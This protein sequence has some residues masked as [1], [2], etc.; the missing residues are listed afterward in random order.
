MN[1]LSSFTCRV[2][3]AIERSIK[4]D[5]DLHEIVL[6]LSFQVYSIK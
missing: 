1:A 4:A 3:D 6:A 5:A 2:D